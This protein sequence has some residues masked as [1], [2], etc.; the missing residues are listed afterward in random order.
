MTEEEDK[1]TET[2]TNTDTAKTTDAPTPDKAP[3][4]P[5]Q[6]TSKQDLTP[7]SDPA[8]DQATDLEKRQARWNT[9]YPIVRKNGGDRP[10][11]GPKK[12]RSQSTP[13]FDWEL[14]QRL[15]QILAERGTLTEACE[16]LAKS[17]EFE[18][19][20]YCAAEDTRTLFSLLEE[21]SEI[22]GE[23]DEVQ[24]RAGR[25]VY[26]HIANVIA[27][28]NSA[29]YDPTI[30]RALQKFKGEREKRRREALQ[31]KTAE[32]AGMIPDISGT[33]KANSTNG[34]RGPATDIDPT[35]TIYDSSYERNTIRALKVM[36]G[37]KD[38]TITD[39]GIERITEGDEK[40]RITFD[41]KTIAE[42]IRQEIQRQNIQSQ[43]RLTEAGEKRQLYPLELEYGKHKLT[44]F[45][46]LETGRVEFFTEATDG[47]VSAAKNGS[48][49][50]DSWGNLN[51]YPDFRTCGGKYLE[52][53]GLPNP[54]AFVIKFLAERDDTLRDK[55][56]ILHDEAYRQ[57]LEINLPGLIQYFNRTIS[58]LEA[59]VPQYVT[60]R[61]TTLR[62]DAL[63]IDDRIAQIEAEE[64]N[65]EGPMPLALTEERQKNESR[66]EEITREIEELRCAST[67]FEDYYIACFDY[68]QVAYTLFGNGKKTNGRKK[69][70]C[71]ERKTTTRRIIASTTQISAD[72]IDSSVIDAIDSVAHD[73]SNNFEIEEKLRTANEKKAALARRLNEKE[74]EL[75]EKQSRREN[76]KSTPPA[77]QKE[78]KTRKLTELPREQN[79]L[80]RLAS[81][82]SYVKEE[83]AQYILA[84]ETA[85]QIERANSKITTITD[86]IMTPREVALIPL[87]KIQEYEEGVHKAA[88]IK[89]EEAVQ[90]GRR[91]KQIAESYTK[92]LEAERELTENIADAS[93]DEIT[94]RLNHTSSAA[95]TLI[96]YENELVDSREFSKKYTHGL[97]KE[98]ANA[99]EHQHRT[100]L[101]TQQSHRIAY[102]TLPTI[103][104]ILYLQAQLIAR[105]DTE[106]ARQYIQTYIGL[107]DDST[108]IPEA[109]ELL[110][111]ATA[112]FERAAVC[113]AKEDL[114]EWK[115]KKKVEREERR[116]QE[117]KKAKTSKETKKEIQTE[118]TQST[119]TIE[120]IIEESA[121]E[122][123]AKVKKIDERFSKNTDEYEKAASAFRYYGEH[124]PQLS[125]M[126]SKILRNT[127]ERDEILYGM[128]SLLKKYIEKA[129]R[130]DPT[131]KQ[132][133][134]HENLNSQNTERFT[135]LT[136]HLRK[137]RDQDTK[138]KISGSRYAKTTK[139]ARIIEDIDRIIQLSS[140]TIQI[141]KAKTASTWSKKIQ[142]QI[143][144][145]RRKLEEEA[146]KETD[147]AK[148]EEYLTQARYALLIRYA[149]EIEILQASR[150]HDF[151]HLAKT[152]A[153]H[154]PQ[155]A[156]KYLLD[157]IYDETLRKDLSNLDET[158]EAKKAEVTNH[159]ERQTN[160]ARLAHNIQVIQTIAGYATEETKTP[161]THLQ[162]A[163]NRITETGERLTAELPTEEP[164]RTLAQ[165]DNINTL[166]GI[167]DEEL[168]AERTLAREASTPTV[169]A[170]ISKHIQR[171]AEEKET[172][173]KK[174]AERIDTTSRDAALDTI[175]TY[176][177]FLTS[178]FEVYMSTSAKSLE[179]KNTY[180]KYGRISREINEGTIRSGKIT[181]ADL[182]RY[183]RKIEHFQQEKNKT[184]RASQK[185]VASVNSGCD[186]KD[187]EIMLKEEQEQNLA[188]IK[189]QDAMLADKASKEIHNA[190][191]Q[192]TKKAKSRLAAGEDIAQVAEE[193]RYHLGRTLTDDYEVFTIQQQK[194]ENAK[195]QTLL[196]LDPQAAVDYLIAR[197]NKV[198][199]D[200][201]KIDRS[202][203][204]TR[205]IDDLFET[206]LEKILTEQ[207]EETYTS[208]AEEVQTYATAEPVTELECAAAMP[209]EQLIEFLKKK[210]QELRDRPE[211]TAKEEPTDDNTLTAMH[212]EHKQ[213]IEQEAKERTKF[214][215]EKTH[216]AKRAYQ[217]IDRL[218]QI[219]YL[220][221]DGKTR[222][223]ASIT[224]EDLDEMDKK[225]FQI[226][227]KVVGPEL[228]KYK[229]QEKIRE[230]FTNAIKRVEEHVK[231]LDE[232]ISAEDTETA[233]E[234]LRKGLA[235]IDYAEERYTAYTRTE[236]QTETTRET[237]KE[238]KRAED[239]L[240]KTQDEN[241]ARQ[242]QH[243]IKILKVS[244]ATDIFPILVLEEARISHTRALALAR[245]DVS[246]AIDY[247]KTRTHDRILGGMEE[248]LKDL[249]ENDKDFSDGTIQALDTY[250]QTKEE[251]LAAR[252]MQ[253]ATD[254]TRAQLTPLQRTANKLKR[255]D[256][257]MREARTADLQAELG[258]QYPGIA[259]ALQTPEHAPTGVRQL[260]QIY[261]R[262]GMEEEAVLS[263]KEQRKTRHEAQK[264]TLESIVTKMRERAGKE[265]DKQKQLFE[266]EASPLHLLH[267]VE[268]LERY[269]P[270]TQEIREIYGA[271]IGQN[272]TPEQKKIVDKASALTERLSKHVRPKEREQYQALTKKID[273]T[274]EKAR[275]ADDELYSS[276]ATTT[277]EELTTK[278][279]ILENLIKE[280]AELREKR[281]IL[282]AGMN[283]YKIHAEE[284]KK[285]KAQLAAYSGTDAARRQEIKEEILA[286]M[287]SQIHE[288]FDAI[289]VQKQLLRTRRT[290]LLLRQDTAL[291]MT[292]IR[293]EIDLEKKD[294]SFDFR[295]TV[296]EKENMFEMQ[297]ME[298]IA[299]RAAQRYADEMFEEIAQYAASGEK[300]KHATETLVRTAERIVQLEDL[301]PR[302][303]VGEKIKDN[304]LEE[305]F[306]RYS[307]NL[308]GEF[309]ISAA[310]LHMRTEYIDQ[311]LEEEKEELAK[312]AQRTED[313][314]TAKERQTNE[315]T[316]LKKI[317]HMSR[318]AM[319]LNSQWLKNHFEERCP[320]NDRLDKAAERMAVYSTQI[321]SILELL[322]ALNDTTT[323]EAETH[324]RIL[325]ARAQRLQRRGLTQ[326]Q[327][328]KY[329]K[330]T[331][332]L[333]DY[334]GKV[335]DSRKKISAQARSNTQLT[336]IENI[337][338]SYGQEVDH[339]Q[340]QTLK[341]HRELLETT[342]RK[343]KEREELTC[344][345]E[346]R[347][348]YDA[349]IEKLRRDLLFTT[350]EADK[351]RI[352]EELTHILSATYR[353]DETIYSLELDLF[354]TT[355]A[356]ALAE[357][358]ADTARRFYQQ[359]IDMHT[360]RSKISDSA[361]D[362][363]DLFDKMKAELNEREEWSAYSLLIGKVMSHA[364]DNPTTPLQRTAN[365]V[366]E[367]AQK[368]P[369]GNADVTI[370]EYDAAT[371]TYKEKKKKAAEVKI[372]LQLKDIESGLRQEAIEPTR[373]LEKGLEA[374]VKAYEAIVEEHPKIAERARR[375]P[376]NAQREEMLEAEG[377]RE[378]IEGIVKDMPSFE[379]PFFE[380]QRA[381]DEYNEKV[382]TMIDRWNTFTEEMRKG[383]QKSRARLVDE[384]QKVRES[385]E[386]GQA[387]VEK[388]KMYEAYQIIQKVVLAGY[389]SLEEQ[390]ESTKYTPEVKEVTEATARIAIKI[391]FNE[392][393]YRFHIIA[394]RRAEAMLKDD[395]ETFSATEI[396]EYLMLCSA[397]TAENYT[398]KIAEEKKMLAKIVERGYITAPQKTKIEKIEF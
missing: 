170:I 44:I 45:A 98:L 17:T 28:P 150:A 219:L 367:L 273:E 214:Y 302:L 266:Q 267:A 169:G 262:Q 289:R 338:S 134:N 299:Q 291:A 183:R 264:Y 19:T 336:E 159:K 187:L 56:R 152:I 204:M 381:A 55:Y 259:Q 25:T 178:A 24:S 351:T 275:K 22:E 75:K 393:V 89:P 372:E 398:D 179:E 102:G 246:A 184:I 111:E 58:R 54:K 250:V 157:K 284:I 243:E 360:M 318:T 65:T 344:A 163:A 124:L 278:A 7:A 350:K 206:Y 34:Q 220:T 268:D 51:H 83:Y 41:N 181:E 362:F 374:A 371:N 333:G 103:Q 119:P 324:Q 265:L 255:L 248:R 228:Q 171:A 293:S 258:E 113:L 62:T 11:F 132:S 317:A 208:I 382:K 303:I 182:Q 247:L 211:E 66:R 274:E 145:D 141:N 234:T 78:R 110:T 328:D 222:V 4:Q 335:V 332:E 138:A 325:T 40:Q 392:I 197:Q 116:V 368:M 82:Y 337:L 292:Y 359:A 270:Y 305:S 33:S 210:E 95:E 38:A 390:L 212:R 109:T 126:H 375:K 191:A 127:P 46:S 323:P 161:L 85:S 172:T 321:D 269:E 254:D 107:I 175:D 320:T 369:D 271:M 326:K 366:R 281:T 12:G 347:K 81:R 52:V 263:V 87:A 192:K 233:L 280:T 287:V 143:E 221:Q 296:E 327:Q 6:P 345:R 32:D 209:K 232:L 241:E 314:A 298:D 295:K 99:T 60:E 357:I 386:D 29:F 376:G 308:Q 1:K 341:E 387:A 156:G 115:E 239:K 174:A 9:F 202:R 213:E 2:D 108:T 3:E 84:I 300:E 370:R 388:V 238:I 195:A 294:K 137:I 168:N 261:I 76:P 63:T 245:Y 123:D 240:A 31:R 135:E 225:R 36:Y 8:P 237:D 354:L 380:Y 236:L 26:R 331:E 301:L 21:G 5:T 201:L 140:A 379:E 312:A 207:Q 128:Q 260:R 15:E 74:A 131:G 306:K 13:E 253:S 384:L 142:S 329:V 198:A 20:R 285:K 340:Q 200:R 190:V 223:S 311:G 27:N 69:S 297:Q 319:E 397:M 73:P 358:S 147:P 346:T 165:A 205:N 242:I 391:P 361:Y 50:L 49:I 290:R 93:E 118:A 23:E 101:L 71:Y 154:D 378:M 162:R 139:P 160:N 153:E 35:R 218:A 96:K 365:K 79:A 72:Q 316:T 196:E 92:L 310:R 227:S 389:A 348:M 86:E 144:E 129:R 334:I 59:E 307:S 100:Y 309:P 286:A 48:T 394:L 57:L 373:Q 10:V 279:T 97:K 272:L 117:K 149:D 151:A 176:E 43:E 120:S 215:K 322:E 105:K 353:E 377:Y 173:K 342:L 304:T 133:K 203:E 256:T 47:K 288:E 122:L 39:L 37:K 283:F 363:K 146:L 70:P 155:L 224:P 88:S 68:A 164:Q 277:A 396:Q 112:D 349:D 130:D 180:E 94:S 64:A 352:Q 18:R 30:K 158:V 53:K 276:P 136:D 226:F 121:K 67:N 385:I 199:E 166:T 125:E 16:F 356:Q 14:R 114:Q 194:V 364:T 193:I 282:R 42:R 185:L 148:K 61:Y 339:I 231:K 104:N 330:K 177:P 257:C 315:E 355:R 313:V 249:E 230:K 106:L 188:T 167:I 77:Q 91:R 229:A 189:S 217:T 383:T 80:E 244:K 395:T 235:L 251:E 216:P 90:L 186:A 252:I 343:H